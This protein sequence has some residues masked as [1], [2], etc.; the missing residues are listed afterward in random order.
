MTDD[1][2][3]GAPA[4]KPI[5]RRLRYE[6]LRRD[7]HTC[8]YCGAQAPDVPLVVDH[9]IPRALGGSDDPTNLT[10]ACQDCN[11]GKSSTTADAQVVAAVDAEAE[12]WRKAMV[13]AAE[14]QNEERVESEDTAA[15]VRDYWRELIHYW[16]PLPFD[17]NDS[18]RTF[19]RNGLTL[20][21]MR[22]AVKETARTGKN[23]RYFCGV[24]WNIIRR[25]QEIARQ[26][27]TEEGGG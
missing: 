8:R 18:V 10:T 23:W 24:C 13:R 14:L 5:S 11:S 1:T 4:A 12:R 6:I 9:V 27:M 17:A 26:I 16:S 7:N 3:I 15:I 20:G 25:R 21:D 19:R 22:Y 2:P